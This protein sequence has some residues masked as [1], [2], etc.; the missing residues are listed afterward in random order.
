MERFTV[1]GSSSFG[2]A[3]GLTVNAQL[4]ARELTAQLLLVFIS[5]CN[6]KIF[7][8]GMRQTAFG[9]NSYF[10]RADRL[11]ISVQFLTAIPL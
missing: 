2:A 3:T 4:R 1:Y 7:E 9:S 8:R 11:E 10:L 5:F 6:T